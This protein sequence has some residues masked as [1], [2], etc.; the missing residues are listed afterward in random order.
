MTEKYKSVID[1]E[2]IFD[3]LLG[4]VTQ[5]RNGD[6][7]VQAGVAFDYARI[8]L[9]SANPELR[10]LNMYDQTLQAVNDAERLL[11][12]RHFVEA[13]KILEVTSYQL[14]EKSGTTEN[15]QSVLNKFKLTK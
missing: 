14:M 6:N 3:Y 7:T 8:V 4:I 9:N 2:N 11:N 1:V 13:Y 10:L 15:L 12:K 5:V